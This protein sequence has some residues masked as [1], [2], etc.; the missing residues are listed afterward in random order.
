MM[1][2]RLNLHSRMG[3]KRDGSTVSQ[4]IFWPAPGRAYTGFGEYNQRELLNRLR[5]RCACRDQLL[6]LIDLVLPVFIDIAEDLRA[7]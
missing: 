5:C 7:N 2:E 1:A 3:L 6:K 4:P